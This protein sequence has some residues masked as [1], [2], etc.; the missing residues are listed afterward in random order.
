[1]RAGVFHGVCS[2]PR[3]FV[4]AL[5]CAAL[6][7]TNVSAMS[8]TF[9]ATLGLIAIVALGPLTQAAIAG[10]DNVD[11]NPAL[12]RYTGRVAALGSGESQGG[13]YSFRAE[14]FGPKSPAKYAPGELRG[15]RLTILTGK[16]F[17]SA[18]EVAGNTE[19]EITVT[20]RDGP[21]AGLAVRDVFVLEQIALRR[22]ADKPAP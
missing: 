18:F 12:K 20:S 17:A 7:S 16:R 3:I 9:G 4:A 15:W 22:P 19:T 2:Q 21:L 11:V 8:P 13:V 10:H 6:A 5:D 14:P 1:L